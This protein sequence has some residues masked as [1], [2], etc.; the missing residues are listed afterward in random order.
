MKVRAGFV[1]NCVDKIK[2]LHSRNLCSQ[3]SDPSPL[4]LCILINTSFP[5]FSRHVE[6]WTAFHE[7][8][9][10]KNYKLWM[11]LCCARSGRRKENPS[12]SGL[13]F[14]C[15]LSLQRE[16]FFACSVDGLRI[17]CGIIKL[18]CEAQKIIG[19]HEI[20]GIYKWIHTN[21][22]KLMI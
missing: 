8:L 21:E 11:A 14:S 16:P 1:E 3:K 5:I 9:Q 22:V 7:H 10:L 15:Y 18:R 13:A 19:F 12:A 6:H 2:N 17:E 4:S 20:L